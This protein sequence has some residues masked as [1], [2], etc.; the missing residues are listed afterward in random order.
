MKTREEQAATMRDAFLGPDLSVAVPW[1]DLKQFVRDRWLAAYDSI[2]TPLDDELWRTPLEFKD[3]DDERVELHMADKYG[4]LLS[5][6]DEDAF[7]TPA[8]AVRMAAWLSSYAS[9]HG[10]PDMSRIHI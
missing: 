3:P 4:A 7:I 2:C 6:V 8:N 10:A 5:V 9:A 1:G